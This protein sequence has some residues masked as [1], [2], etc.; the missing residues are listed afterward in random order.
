MGQRKTNITYFLPYVKST[1][2][3]IYM[4]MRKKIRDYLEGEK[5]QR[6]VMG[7]NKKYRIHVCAKVLMEH[8]F[9]FLCQLKMIMMM[10]PYRHERV[11]VYDS[12]YIKVKQN[13]I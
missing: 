8:I 4:Y 6:S 9:Y 12:F 5:G 13:Q 3:S 11:L 1:F 10:R 2:S 7:M